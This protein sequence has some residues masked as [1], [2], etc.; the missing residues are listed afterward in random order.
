MD[1]TLEMPKSPWEELKDII[2]DFLRLF[3]TVFTQDGEEA[4]VDL[5][6][7]GGYYVGWGIGTGGAVKGDSDLGTPSTESR[8]AGT[9]TQPSADIFQNVATITSLSGQSISEVGLFDAAGTGNPP[10]GGILIIRKDFTPIPL[11]T[12]DQIEFT[13]TL[14]MT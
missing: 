11:L 9:P 1:T 5:I 8:S 2:E 14:E 6:D 3:A 7:V 4:V 10:S 13:I 12:D